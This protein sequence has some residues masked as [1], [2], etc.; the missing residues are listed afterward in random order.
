MATIARIKARWTIPGAGTA[1]SVFHFGNTI[2]E[3]P[4]QA[5]ADAALVKVTAFFESV[6]AYLPNV[7]SVLVLNEVELIQTNNGAM[8]GI[9]AGP[10]QA[11]KTG[12]AAATAGW[13]AAAGGVISWST[14][15]VRNNRRVRGRNFLVPLSNEVWDTDGTMKAVP[16]SGI[17]S[18]ATALRDQTGEIDLG[19]YARPTAPGA[20][21]GA[22]Y[23]V[24][25][26]RVPDFSAIL[27]SRRA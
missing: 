23:P 14:P 4:V 18:A 9:L 3:D 2:L 22:Y 20:T 6:K 27:R 21:D 11:T 15:G 16:L 24:T 25:G 5:Q 7:V 17:N 13:A 19:V 12:T 26:H 10:T 1:F 8:T